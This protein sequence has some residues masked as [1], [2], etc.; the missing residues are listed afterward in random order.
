MHTTMA[1]DEFT[2]Y[3][4]IVSQVAEPL[5]TAAMSSSEPGA[6]QQA[7]GRA[8]AA[9]EGSLAL[10]VPPALLLLHD[11]PALYPRLPEGLVQL[12]RISGQA[13]GATGHADREP[14]LADGAGHRRPIYY[15]LVLH[16]YLAAYRRRFEGL[17][18]EQ[19]RA[20]DAAIAQAAAPARVIENYAGEAVL[21]GAGA[22]ET[23]LALWWSLCILDQAR[24]LALDDDVA[25]V[26]RVVGVIVRRRG[27]RGALHPMIDGESLDA[28]TYR[29]L[30]ALHALANVALARWDQVWTRRVAEIAAYHLE[31][32]QPDHTTTQPWALFAFVWTPN[33]RSLGEQ[34]INDLQVQSAAG[35]GAP[36]PAPDSGGVMA[37]L[38]L[39]DAADAL[40]NLGA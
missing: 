9:P 34:Q 18:A 3:A 17:S 27:R 25:L 24:A 33:T 8:A 23:P 21:P 2:R 20:C 1:L 39:A 6:I 26:D 31:N 11:D 5:L 37:G 10:G 38:L 19:R 12:A 40:L 35:P 36:G 15:P 16:L 7:T 4:A 22:E 13:S 14:M 29:E 28:W 32:T 30:C